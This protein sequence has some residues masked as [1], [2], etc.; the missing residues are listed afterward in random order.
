ML[1]FHPQQAAQLQFQ[2][3]GPF[4]RRTVA[5]AIP[6]PTLREVE[7]RLHEYELIHPY[8]E[9]HSGFSD[10][11]ETPHRF[12]RSIKRN[13]RFAVTRMSAAEERFDIS[14]QTQY[15]AET[16]QLPD[17]TLLVAFRG[18]DDSLTGW[19]EDFNMAFTYP[20]PAQKRAADY[21]ERW[22][23]SGRTRAS[24]SPATPRAAISRS[25]QP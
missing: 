1:R 16:F 25:T 17:G 23:D 18:T 14:Q 22:A 24:C 15:A 2:T 3:P 7:E 5:Y 8:W 19:R 6:G 20:I 4:A 12:Y 10:D 11:D 9:H 21:L 13:P